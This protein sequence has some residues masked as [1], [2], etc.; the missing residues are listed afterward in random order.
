L[1][2]ERSDCGAVQ[3]LLDEYVAGTL[4][5][6]GAA[7]VEKHLE[8]CEVCRRDMAFIKALSRMVREHEV[9]GRGYHLEADTLL[10]LALE[11]DSMDPDLRKRAQGHLKICARCDQDLQLLRGVSQHLGLGSEDRRVHPWS[12]RVAAGLR[13]LRTC[14]MLIP[15]TAIVIV[16]VMLA[17]PVYYSKQDM[18][19]ESSVKANMHTLQ[20]A[21]ED[22]AVETD[23]VYPDHEGSKT[24][25]GN[26]V[27]DLCPDGDYPRN[28]FTG[29]VTTVVWDGD[30][31]APGD[32]G[33]NPANKTGYV[34]K[35]HG[36][37]E[38]LQLELR[39]HR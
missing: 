3:D 6:E 1:G 12:M 34:I 26:T 18:A 32:I 11:P 37:R 8:E 10:D 13:A 19:K 22:F 36:R 27:R 28:P 33:I 7:L 20:L 31:R 21:V 29:K 30:P 24:P 2:K 23:G 25:Q 17:V 5:G 39:P 14:W 4:D 35:G 38:M 9:S 16:L 15:I